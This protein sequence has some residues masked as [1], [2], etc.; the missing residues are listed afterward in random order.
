MNI[1]LRLDS[2]SP[3]A[4]YRQLYSELRNGI[5]TGRF[6]AGTKLPG[7]R[8]LADSLGISRVT[9]TECYERLASE[10]YLETRIRSGTFVCQNL[11]DLSFSP[12]HVPAQEALSRSRFLPYFSRY[13][14][15]LNNP[16]RRPDPPGTIRLNLHGSD[17]SKFPVRIW[18]KLQ[19]RRLE[20]RYEEL[21]EYTQ[22]FAGNLELR[23]AVTSYL[24]KSR[25]VVCDPSQVIIV[26]GSQQ[27]IYL[28][29]RVFLD[30][31]DRIAI[32]SPGYQLAGR[33]FA[34]QGAVLVPVPVDRN[35]IKVSELK[36]HAGNCKLVYVTPSHQFPTGVSLSVSRRMELLGW[37]REKN[38]LIIEDD[39]DSEFRYRGRPLPSVQGM[40]SD[41]PVLYIGTF[42]K[43]LFSTL[44]LGYVVVPPSVRDAFIA[45]KLLS[46][47]QS[48][49]L[50]QAVLADF[51]SEHHLEPHI[52]RMR[53]IYGRRRALFLQSLHKQFGSKVKII[54]D[55]AGMHL[56]AEFKTRFSESEAFQ[57][58][59][60]NGVR[61]EQIYWPANV[62]MSRPGCVAFVC[63]FAGRSDFEI[64]LAAERLA[65]AFL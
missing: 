65:R 19:R 50:Q 20:S 43:L 42:S 3:T 53:T 62:V 4:L 54:G 40:V 27:A 26:S 12:F 32:E 45:A 13:G 10:G 1:L 56:M 2:K 52:R 33:V 28:A 31:G 58:A 44:R 64:Q 46:D 7:S 9:V 29:A 39:Y 17:V 14:V 34:S 15:T 23:R 60:D 8:S 59:F 6:E 16:L 48:S 36:R 51:M 22:D 38:V 24:R 49:S 21:L 57:R 61:L 5:L 25:A 35:G 11:P 41:P 63:A 55:N 30:E 18:S 37:A 47:F